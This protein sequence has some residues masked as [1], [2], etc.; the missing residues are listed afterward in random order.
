MMPGLALTPKTTRRGVI[1]QVPVRPRPAGV[2]DLTRFRGTVVNNDTV[3]KV[4]TINVG[5]V[6]SQGGLSKLAPIGFPAEI[7]YSAFSRVR[8]YSQFS[9]EGTVELPASFG[10]QIYSSK[11]L[12]S[13][14]TR[15][16]GSI[17]PFGG[18]ASRP[19]RILTDVRLTSDRG[20]ILPPEVNPVVAGSAAGRSFIS[21]IISALGDLVGFSAGSAAA[22]AIL[23][24][25]IVYGELVGN[26]TSSTTALAFLGG[27][28]D[29]T[30][31]VDSATSS[32]GSL[33]AIV[34][35][36]GS[37]AGS[38]FVLL[39]SE[40]AVAG[41]SDSVSTV[42]ATLSASG[43]LA[44]TVSSSAVSTAILSATGE[45]EAGSSDSVSTVT[46]TAS[47]TGSLVGTVS[48]S[49]TT[50]ATLNTL[51]GLIGTVSSSTAS[52]ATLSATGSLV[53]TVSSSAS[54]TA[55]LTAA[56]SLAGQTAGLAVG[57]ATLTA[58]GALVG[59][60][61]GVV[62]IAGSLTDGSTPALPSGFSTF[63]PTAYSGNRDANEPG[64]RIAYIDPTL[65][66][67]VTGEYYYWDGTQVV[68]STTG[69]YGTDPLNPT[70]AI[71]P[72][73]TATGHLRQ[74]GDGFTGTRHP[75]WV[76]MKRGE[77]LP[78]VRIAEQRRRL[79]RAARAHRGLRQSRRPPPHD[80]HLRPFVLL[81]QRRPDAHLLH[82]LPLARHGWPR[83]RHEAAWRRGVHPGEPGERGR[84]PARLALVR[85]HADPG[86]PLRRRGPGRPYRGRHGHAEIVAT[87][88]IRGTTP[89]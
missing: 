42:T 14:V 59:Q 3:N 47:A 51:G 30:G 63:V 77:I 22:D 88:A 68:D 57:A 16:P 26:I 15:R 41:S 70:G 19:Y 2:N 48:S 73:A 38:A 17:A 80:R 58:F 5:A 85:R 61:N 71:Q 25:L 66:S 4:L 46:A 24:E 20:V 54:S 83:G 64:T 29:I 39:V 76:L 49:T 55:T 9:L 37:S 53:G 34:D 27:L 67:D 12:V 62:V 33:G 60:A 6:N 7:H 81:E 79:A 36:A 43:A 23:S 87:L 18:T 32:V 65:G 72:F 50:A 1:W 52:T 75:D 82:S 44:G 86:Y 35:I 13:R 40:G 28:A 74:G 11:L 89:P 84:R 69:T 10:G 45:L 78:R 31:S 8:L 56:D 21:G